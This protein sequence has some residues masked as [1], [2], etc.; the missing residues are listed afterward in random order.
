MII[1]DIYLRYLGFNLRFELV[2]CALEFIEHF[3]YL[4]PDFWQLLGP[5]NQ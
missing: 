2:R 1:L 5:E 4:P 3:S